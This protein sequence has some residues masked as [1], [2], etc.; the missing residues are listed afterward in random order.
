MTNTRGKSVVGYKF[1]SPEFFSVLGIDIVR[2]RGFA[3]TERS[4]S[5]AVAVVSESVARQLWPSR[6]AVGEVLRLEPDPT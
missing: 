1:V 5:V 6:D 3:P 4:A 2:G